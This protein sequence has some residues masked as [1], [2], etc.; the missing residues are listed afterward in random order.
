MNGIPIFDKDC[1]TVRRYRACDISFKRQQ[2][3]HWILETHCH[4]LYTV[5]MQ[6]LRVQSY[7]RSLLG[8]VTIVGYAHSYQCVTKDQFDTLVAQFSS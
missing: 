7:G 8:I 6:W 1:F 4:Q 3:E 2:D 5:Q